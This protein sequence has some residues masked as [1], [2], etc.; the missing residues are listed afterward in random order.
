MKWTL[1][2]LAILLLALLAGG[3]AAQAQEGYD[4]SWWTVDGG[5]ATFS[6]GGD[7]TLGGT[8]AQHD[9]G[10]LSG[11]KYTL[12]G[13]FWAGGALAPGGYRIMYLPQIYSIFQA[14]PPIPW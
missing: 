8:A 7:Y 1:P 2:I 11:G 6:T 13:G 3:E 9:A 12:S 14:E 5:G 10:E 4:L